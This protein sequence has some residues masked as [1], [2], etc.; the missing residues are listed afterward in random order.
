MEIS[1]PRKHFAIKFG[2]L[3]IVLTI[4]AFAV[5]AFAIPDEVYRELIAAFLMML[6]APFLLASISAILTLRPDLKSLKGMTIGLLVISILLI[7]YST[8]LVLTHTGS[9]ANIGGLAPL[10]FS[11]I[12]YCVGGYLGFKS[13]GLF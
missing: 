11:P 1:K 13:G 10:F 12:F 2:S 6:G 8:F 3:G 5:S 7:L 9:G 4:L